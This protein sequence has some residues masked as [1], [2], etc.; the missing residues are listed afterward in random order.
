MLYSPVQ[1]RKQSPSSR[2]TL[3]KILDKMH[4][5]VLEFRAPR[6][7][8]PPASRAFINREL[9]LHPNITQLQKLMGKAKLYPGKITIQDLFSI[10][11]LYLGILP[12]ERDLLLDQQVFIALTSLHTY[13][14][15]AQIRETALEILDSVPEGG[16]PSFEPVA[17]SP[18]SEIE[19]KAI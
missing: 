4:T 1:E 16:V 6:Q 10:K 15:R 9:S 14:R 13:A 19:R 2:N 12:E 7:S 17:I 5:K 8:E 11:E 18:S 3:R